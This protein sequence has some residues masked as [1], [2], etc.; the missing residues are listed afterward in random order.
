MEDLSDSPMFT[1]DGKYIC[2]YFDSLL[3][4]AGREGRIETLG[5]ALC[6]ESSRGYSRG[7]RLPSLQGLE[8]P[9]M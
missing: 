9:A 1:D 7:A 8:E 6:D 4:D 2:I 3:V 5:K